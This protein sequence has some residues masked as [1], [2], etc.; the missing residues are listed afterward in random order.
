M[1]PDNTI[2]LIIVTT[3]EDVDDEFNVNQPLRVLFNRALQAVGGQGDR[4]QFSLEFDDT[5][6]TD[7]DRKIGDWAE[8]FGWDDGTA[9]ELVPKPVVV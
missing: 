7:L 2:R 3:A 6:L 4:D 8:Q 9:I 5:D 1:P